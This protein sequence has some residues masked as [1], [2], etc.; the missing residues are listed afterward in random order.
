MGS[1]GPLCHQLIWTFYSSNVGGH[2]GQ[3]ATFKSFS[4][5]LYFP[6]MK[7]M[8]V[9]FEVNHRSKDENVPYQ[10]LLQPLPIPD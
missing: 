6:S 1:N 5:L 8:M 7:Q 4:I 3:L 2:S 9:Q 10:G